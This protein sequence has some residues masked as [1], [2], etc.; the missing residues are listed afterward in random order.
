MQGICRRLGEADY[1]AVK[2]LEEENQEKT[3]SLDMCIRIESWEIHRFFR[4][5][6][7][8]VY[9]AF[10]A[11]RLVALFAV[12]RPNAEENMGHYMGFE[13]DALR[14]LAHWELAHV[15]PEYRGNGLQKKLG[16]FCFDDLLVEWPDVTSLFA[17][18]YPLNWPSLKS[19][20]QHGFVI[21]NLHRMYGGHDRYILFR[22]THNNVLAAEEPV[23][24]SDMAHYDRHCEL[25]E[26]GYVGTGITEEHGVVQLVFRRRLR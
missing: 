18:I 2:Q 12:V 14:H 21:I 23:V 16:A 5:Q 17:T 10:A 19:T 22:K 4:P 3:N 25:F 24:L 1:D 7:A 8:I 13:G 9:G 15:L 6:E 20:F 26:Q 11:E